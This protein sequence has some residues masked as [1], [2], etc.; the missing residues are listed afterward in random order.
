MRLFAALVP[1]PD[2]LDHLQRALDL[3][4][5]PGGRRSPWT[6]RDTWHLTV[7]FYGEVP[8]GRLSGLAEEI[9]EAVRDIPAFSCELAGAGQFRHTASWVGVRV[10]ERPWRALVA[11]LAPSEFGLPGAVDQQARNRPHLTVSRAH[12]NAALDDAIT[13][14]AVYR[15]PSWL[16]TE[17]VL[18]QSALGQGPGGHPLYTP[19]VRAPLACHAG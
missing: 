13:A 12:D 9:P 3:L 10:E 18:F 17:V 14:L 8:D 5:V 7:A 2:V 15:G 6:P 4:G 1:P 11:A 19:L 16:V